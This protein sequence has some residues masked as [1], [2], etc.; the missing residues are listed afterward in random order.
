MNIFLLVS[1]AE[2]ISSESV[3][4]L[5]K[6]TTQRLNQKS[7]RWMKGLVSKS[8]KIDWPVL[9]ICTGTIVTAKLCLQLS[10][11]RPFTGCERDSVCFQD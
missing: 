1:L 11:Q 4:D 7:V 2:L 10:E 3:D 6:K 9:D 5:G 8:V